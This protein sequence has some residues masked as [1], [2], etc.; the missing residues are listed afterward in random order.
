MEPEMHNG[1]YK[2]YIATHEH[3]S[4]SD[5][6]GNS[7]ILL[8]HQ[9]DVMKAKLTNLSPLEDNGYV[10][11][12]IAPSDSDAGD[13]RVTVERFFEDEDSYTDEQRIA[14]ATDVSHIANI[15]KTFKVS[16]NPE[17]DKL[18]KAWGEEDSDAR[19]KLEEEES[20]HFPFSAVVEFVLDAG[21]VNIRID[22]NGVV[23]GY[24]VTEYTNYVWTPEESN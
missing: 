2:K 23:S 5:C 21:V 22:D 12:L 3:L 19:K 9:L 15:F 8:E 4:P 13:K 17:W 11:D 20:F 14:W 10:G 7:I 1:R 18:P 16:I 24:C 6:I